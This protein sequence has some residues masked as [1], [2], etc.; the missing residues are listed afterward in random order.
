M[1]TPSSPLECRNWQCVLFSDTNIS[2]LLRADGRTGIYRRV[3]E[4]TAPYCIQE[5]MGYYRVGYVADRGHV[6]WSLMEIFIP[7]VT[8]TSCYVDPV[9]EPCAA[10]AKDLGSTVHCKTSHNSCCTTVSGNDQR[11]AMASP[12]TRL[13]SHRTFL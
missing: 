10:H 8:L 12:I 6:W 11:F 2:Q 13:A 1:G 9:V 3:G 5:T 7:S 4:G